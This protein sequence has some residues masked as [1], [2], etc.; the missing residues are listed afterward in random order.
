MIDASAVGGSTGCCHES[1]AGVD[2][3]AK[4]LAS[5]PWEQ[6]PHPLVPGI[7]SRFG[8][9]VLEAV[10]AIKEARLFRARAH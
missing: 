2:E 6:R 9:S 10:Q 3:A 5:T 8:L 7:R 4:W 1:S